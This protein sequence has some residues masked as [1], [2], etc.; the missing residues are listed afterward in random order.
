[1]QMH[2]V[3][4]AAIVQQ[5]NAAFPQTLAPFARGNG[6]GRD[7]ARI[8]TGKLDYDTDGSGERFHRHRTTDSPLA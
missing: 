5:R 1:M 4:G 7:R 2:V 3:G 6:K 8:S